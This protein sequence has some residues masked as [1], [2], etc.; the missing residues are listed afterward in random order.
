MSEP[1]DVKLDNLVGP[2]IKTRAVPGEASPWIDR[3]EPA[4]E[5]RSVVHAPASAALGH[6]AAQTSWPSARATARNG[7]TARCVQGNGS[8][9]VSPLL[10]ARLPRLLRPQQDVRGQ[11]G[12][13]VAE[14]MI[15]PIEELH[16]WGHRRLRKL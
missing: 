14:A 6:G 4:P 7:R 5:Q 2:H 15:E 1:I 9:C 16:Q 11:L 13:D 8:Y 10:G 12:H 3:D